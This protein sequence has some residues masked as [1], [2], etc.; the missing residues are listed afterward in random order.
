MNKKIK[1]LK[2]EL[3][4]KSFKVITNTSGV[5]TGMLATES[6]EKRI[7]RHNSLP[8]LF[9]DDYICIVNLNSGVASFLLIDD[10]KT[11]SPVK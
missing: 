8:A 11:I 9:N 1:K 3:G 6:I 7:K 10:I 4:G 5:V 2:R